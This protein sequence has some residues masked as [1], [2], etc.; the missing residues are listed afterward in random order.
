MDILL[1]YAVVMI[2]ASISTVQK[3][4]PHLK[5]LQLLSILM[6]SMGKQYESMFIDLEW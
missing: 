3:A 2:A 1:L 5:I 6:V 4:I